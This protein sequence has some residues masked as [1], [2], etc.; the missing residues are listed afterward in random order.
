[1]GD[2]HMPKPLFKE[3]R[4]PNATQKLNVC[5]LYNQNIL[6]FRTLKP[7]NAIKAGKCYVKAIYKNPLDE[8]ISSA[9]WWYLLRPSVSTDNAAVYSRRWCCHLFYILRANYGG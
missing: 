3:I 8:N 9:T 7:I 6:N 1:M 5:P 4:K 2:G